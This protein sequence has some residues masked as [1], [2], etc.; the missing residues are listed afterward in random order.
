MSSESVNSVTESQVLPDR[1]NSLGPVRQVR[2]SAPGIRL[3]D[4]VAARLN[5]PGMHWDRDIARFGLRVTPTG[6]K[7]WVLD[8]DAA[9]G[10][11]R[12]INIGYFPEDM[13]AA[14]ARDEA[15][16]LRR[17]IRDGHDP[18]AER[19]AERRR[20][21]EAPSVG[22]LCADWLESK[23][24]KR[25]LRDDVGM[26]RKHIL[27]A[28]GAIRVAEVRFDDIER[29]HRRVART[30]PIRANRTVSLL[31]AMFERAIKRGWYERANPAAGI[32]RKGETKR[33]R[34]LTT[35][36]LP[37]L[38]AALEDHRSQRSA[39]LIRL[40]LYTGARRGEA[41]KA[42]WSEFDLEVGRW[43]KP[44]AHTKQREMHSIPLNRPALDLL[45]GMRA[46]APADAIYVFPGDDATGHLT[47]VKKS[48]AA[49]CQRAGLTDLR[50]HDLR[51]SF[52]SLLLNRGASLEVIGGLLG[53]TQSSTTQRYAHLLEETLREA[54]EK[55]EDALRE[56]QTPS[57]P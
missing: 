45:T 15:L 49:T 6:N 20:H 30:A 27:P 5:T 48:W 1:L 18:Y 17:L 33:R 26:I 13:D 40:L 47:D 2:G 10:K 3:S 32:E 34:Y 51:H 14:T 39:N 54:S 44:D 7:A 24:E 29:L 57:T 23:G 50:L 12:R 42:R 21:L 9:G 8:Y 4:T 52:A 25:S 38:L 41:L 36:E 11:R 56:R 46:A 53:H 37:R 22:D 28:L 19:Q 55:F 35:A 16:R 43:T 31:H